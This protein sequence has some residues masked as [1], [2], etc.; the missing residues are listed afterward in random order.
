MTTQLPYILFQLCRA[1][2]SVVVEVVSPKTEKNLGKIFLLQFV[3][4]VEG[5]KKLEMEF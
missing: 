1:V 5:S 4:V 2:Y 3:V